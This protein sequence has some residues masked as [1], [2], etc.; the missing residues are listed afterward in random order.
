MEKEN[1]ISGYCRALDAARTVCV[2]T[3]DGRLEEADCAYGSC[4]HQQACTIAR[5]IDDLQNNP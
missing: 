3:V 1:F 4:P 2:L 5:Q